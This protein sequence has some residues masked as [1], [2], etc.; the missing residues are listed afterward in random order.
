MGAAKKV[1]GNKIVGFNVLKKK[2]P[3]ENKVKSK[4]FS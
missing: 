3:S 2:V 1:L 4:K